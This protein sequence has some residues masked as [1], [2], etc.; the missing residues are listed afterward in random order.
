M[1]GRGVDQI[2][3]HPGNPELHESGIRDARVY[4]DL[5]ER[6]NG[7]IRRPVDASYVWG[8]ALAE[9]EL[10]APRFRVVNLE[11]TI[12]KSDDFWNDKD[13]HYRMS[14]D[15]VDCLLA[16]KIDCCS[17]ANNHALDWGSEGLVATLD[18]L[19]RAGVS[20]AGAGRNRAEAQRPAIL[21]TTADGG[22]L[23]VFALGFP[24][25]GVLP[26]WAATESRAGVYFVE[27]PSDAA[28][29][30]IGREIERVKTG[31][32][33]VIVSLHWGANWGY[34]VP[35]A[36]VRFAHSLIDRGADIVHGHSSHHPGPIEV[37]RNKLILY[38]C[39]DF[40]DDY[41]GIEGYESFRDDLVLM[42]FA[43][44]S[45]RSGELCDLRLAPMQ[46]AKMRLNRATAQDA[47]WLANTLARASRRFA[48]V[49]SVGEDG[50][51]FL[52]H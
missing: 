38:G 23:L 50:R 18:T 2:L 14:P 7:V 48:T 47:V 31:R 42:Y 29:R 37:Y 43:T 4:V 9:W 11:T 10:V 41:E 13:I 19:E 3:L 40:I 20:I 22:R 33:R 16:A 6:K 26:E 34:E 8:D 44:V 35:D 45:G 52:R 5:A 36:H 49:V 21:G 28:A 15:N 46:I 12:T 17:L 24:S 32:D 1:T 27:A 51:L 30:Q 39:G 25:S